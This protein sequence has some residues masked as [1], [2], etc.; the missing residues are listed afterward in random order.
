MKA[1]LCLLLAVLV[2]QI[3]K[4][5]IRLKKFKQK[6]IGTLGIKLYEPILPFL[7]D[8]VKMDIHCNVQLVSYKCN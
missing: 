3:V 6:I 7:E 4:Q 5:Q 8:M 2:S 1:D